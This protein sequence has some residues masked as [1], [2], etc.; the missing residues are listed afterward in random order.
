[1][2]FKTIVYIIIG[3]FW[4]LSRFFQK[5]KLERESGPSEPL[6]E[7]NVS[8]E[9]SMP[10]RQPMKR[11]SLPDKKKASSGRE[12]SPA[13]ISLENPAVHSNSPL[14]KRATPPPAGSGENAVIGSDAERISDEIRNGQ[15]DWRRAVII[16]ELINRKSGF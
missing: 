10:P 7:R 5:A 8:P 2:E 13:A 4:L 11:G 3:V 14:V 16:S 12:S 15:F 6:P 1:M 9:R